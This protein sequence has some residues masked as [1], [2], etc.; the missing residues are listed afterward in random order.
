MPPAS[1]SA[2]VTS[3][4]GV[5]TPRTCVQEGVSNSGV[6]FRSC[7]GAQYLSVN[8]HR[9]PSDTT[10]QKSIWKIPRHDEC[11]FFCIGNISCWIDSGGNRWSI[12]KDAGVV[13]GT[14][15]ERVAFYQ[16]PVNQTDPWHGF[17]VGGKRALPMR[18]RP[19]DTLLRQWR[20]SGWISAVTYDRLLGGRL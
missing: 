11:H 12:S 9:S 3:P 8:Y 4:P 18:R 16:Q 1:E 19:P 10:Y 13:M 15:G 2:T 5:P 14:R 17:P 6:T 7:N 20:E